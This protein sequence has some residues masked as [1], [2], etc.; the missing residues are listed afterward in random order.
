M[1]SL[2]QILKPVM[3]NAQLAKKHKV[4]VKD[5]DSQVNMGSEVE[6]EHTTN[7]KVAETIARAHVEEDPHYYDKLKKIEKKNDRRH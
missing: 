3:N 2:K 7:K 5:I 1:K 4:T 6:K